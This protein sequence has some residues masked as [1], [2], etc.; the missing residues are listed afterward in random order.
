MIEF[1][2]QSS[3]FFLQ[4]ETLK[5]DF[6][7]Q[8]ET[9]VKMSELMG[10]TMSFTSAL[11]RGTTFTICL[12]FEKCKSSEIPQAVRVDAGDSDVIQGLRVLLVE[13]N[14]L[15]ARSHSLRSTAPV[16]S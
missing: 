14:D 6:M 12:P 2:R 4:D 11:G 3:D 13:D 9:T 10:G 15:N 16:P 1:L 8:L 7:R 5:A